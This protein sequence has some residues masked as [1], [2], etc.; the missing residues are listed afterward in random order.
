MSQLLHFL[1]PHSTTASMLHDSAEGRTE[2]GQASLS[3]KVRDDD[4]R[5]GMRWKQSVGVSAVEGEEEAWE[6]A[7]V[8][9]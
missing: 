1:F 8:G 4:P 7:A 3:A 9:G 6:R 2:V 5:A